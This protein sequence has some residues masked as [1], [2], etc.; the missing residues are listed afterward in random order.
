MSVSTNRSQTQRPFKMS[1]LLLNEKAFKLIFM[2]FSIVIVVSCSILGYDAY[3]AYINPEHVYGK[4][5]E[6]GGPNY[7]KEILTLSEKGVYKNNHLISTSFQFSGSTVT[8]RTGDGTT[9][10]EL[11]GSEDAPQLK[12][13]KPGSPTQ[14]F[15]KHGY[16][17]ELKHKQQSGSQERR[18]ILSEHFKEGK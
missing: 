11:D 6:I 7:N 13:I 10:Y 8:V 4:W 14:A 15:V 18:L 16:E 9:K 2:A 3:K 17:A 5:V 12:R 1:N